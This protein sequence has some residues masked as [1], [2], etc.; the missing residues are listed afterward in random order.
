MLQRL[1]HL[2][3][4]KSNRM[5]RNV[6]TLWIFMGNHVTRILV[7]MDLARLDGLQNDIDI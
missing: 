4:T 6:E 7:N 2:M 5:L 1:A 3:K